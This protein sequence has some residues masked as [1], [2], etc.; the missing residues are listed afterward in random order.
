MCNVLGAG[1]SYVG[2][3]CFSNELV[4]VGG[5]GVGVR[6]CTDLLGVDNA[7]NIFNKFSSSSFVIDPGS[8]DKVWILNDCD[9]VGSPKKSSSKRCDKDLFI[10]GVVNI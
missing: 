4:W 8:S 5:Y 1:V 2:F 10:D 9:S 7:V 6:F 3:S